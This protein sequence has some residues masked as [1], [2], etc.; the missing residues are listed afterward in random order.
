MKFLFA[1]LWCCLG[2]SLTF[3]DEAIA[4]TDRG[5]EKT[6]GYLQRLE[7]YYESTQSPRTS[8]EEYEVWRKRIQFA[9]NQYQA[10]LANKIPI[11]VRKIN[12]LEVDYVNSS[13]NATIPMGFKI[14]R[15][16]HVDVVNE[17]RLN[18]DV[19]PS[20]L[21]EYSKFKDKIYIQLGGYF[22][23]FKTYVVEDLKVIYYTRPIYHE[24]LNSKR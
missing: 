6:E 12:N 1:F 22:S 11:E 16:R 18:F 9:Q 7:H 4:F 19:E 24:T 5:K 17:L 15:V 2:A 21:R 10:I 3:G 8:F 20:N 13:I 23:D 14:Q